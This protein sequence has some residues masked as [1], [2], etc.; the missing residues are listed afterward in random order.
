MYFDRELEL[1]NH[2]D[3]SGGI[4]LT[5]YLFEHLLKILYYFCSMSHIGQ[6]PPLF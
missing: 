1:E 2:D 3:D 5:F 6:P 4:L